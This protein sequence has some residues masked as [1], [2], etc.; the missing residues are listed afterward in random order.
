MLALFYYCYYYYCHQ[1][2]VSSF[3]TFPME[4][5]GP[6]LLDSG[7]VVW[8]F[9]NQTLWPVAGFCGRRAVRQGRPRSNPACREWRR[10]APSRKRGLA[11]LG[12]PP[13]E[14]V[15]SP[16][17]CPPPT[18]PRRALDSSNRRSPVTR[19]SQPRFCLLL[20]SLHKGGL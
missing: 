2:K 14:A 13:V 10:G 9:L 12:R 20:P 8:P 4:V 11:R 15:T 3:S 18:P 1:E 5:P 7:W 6:A 16:L 19:G 17:Q